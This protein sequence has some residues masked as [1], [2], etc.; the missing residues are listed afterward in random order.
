MT[1]TEGRRGTREKAV[2]VCLLL[3]LSLPAFVSSANGWRI[4][5][6]LGLELEGLDESQQTQTLFSGPSNSGVGDVSQALDNP[7]LSRRVTPQG[8]IE[9]NGWSGGVG[10]TWLRLTD[11][12]RFARTRSRNSLAAEG[13]LKRAADRF[14]FESRW[15]VQGGSDEPAAGSSATLT[16]TWDHDLLP[17]GIESQIR[18]RGDWSRTS[19]RDLAGIFDYRTFRGHL[20]LRRDFGRRIELRALG[21]YRRKSS[22]GGSRIGSYDSRIGELEADGNVR[23]HD[24]IEAVVRIED[25]SYMRD[26]SGIP[27][28]ILTNLS[29]R[30]DLQASG[31]VRPYMEQ[32]LELQNYRIESGIFQDHQSWTTEAGTDLFIRRPQADDDSIGVDL[33][34]DWR[35]RLGGRSEIFRASAV[36]ADSIAFLPAFD[37]FGVVTGLAREGGDFFWCDLTFEVGRRLY[38]DHSSAQQLVFEGLNL[39]LASSDYTYLNASAMVQWTPV[40]WIRA[41]AIVQWDDERHDRPQD[42]FRIWIANLSLT[43]P[44]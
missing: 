14:R 30:Y 6:R 34:P 39:S 13:S 44:F 22:F 28:S 2:R 7:I 3:C 11:T 38:R 5:G 4:G 15:D 40:P 26:R 33:A 10:R 12:A 25:R 35:L 29:A 27:S 1:R 32:G 42:N 9:L 37:S 24:H 8:M 16:T 23:E 31:A 20:Q 41:E 19:N 43:H 18:L 21:G 17:L 36:D